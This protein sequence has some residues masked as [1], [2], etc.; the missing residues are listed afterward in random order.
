MN[1]PAV[2]NNVL[3]NVLNMNQVRS[4]NELRS[5]IETFEQLIAV[6]DDDL[7]DFVKNTHAANS[8]R[9]ANQRVLIPTSVVVHHNRVSIRDGFFNL[10]PL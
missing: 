7:L 5:F 2:F 10:L 4:R 9:A 8:A 1:D 3:I 6:S